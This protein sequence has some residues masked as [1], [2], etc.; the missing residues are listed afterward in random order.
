MRKTS[1]LLA[2]ACMMTTLPLSAKTFLQLNFNETGIT[3]VEEVITTGSVIRFHDGSLSLTD[4][5]SEGIVLSLG[6]LSR[7]TF[8]TTPTGITGPV[9]AREGFGLVNNVVSDALQVTVPSDFTKADIAIVSLSGRLVNRIGGWQ[10][11]SV[12]VSSLAPGL[13]LITINSQTLK[14]IKQ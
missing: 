3:P 8:I 6:D 7:L 10:G 13:Y 11:E 9:M 5:A 2:S 14:F 12:D 4:K 1:L